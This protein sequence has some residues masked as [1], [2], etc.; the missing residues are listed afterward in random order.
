MRLYVDDDK[1]NIRIVQSVADASNM[2]SSVTGVIKQF[3]LRSFPKNIFKNVYIDTSET[4]IQKNINNL[5]NPLLDKR[6]Y[7]SLSITPELTIDDPIGGMS[8]NPIASSPISFL[9]RDLYRSYSKLLEDP[10]ERF[11]VHFSTDYITTNLNVKIA[12][13]SYDQNV[14]MGLHLKSLF[15]FG[16]FNYLEGQIIETEFPKT[17]VKII[18]G[19]KGLELTDQADMDI[20]REYLI[21]T[22][23]RKGMIV[24]KISLNTGKTCFFF[25]EQQN[26]LTL[27]SDLDVP[28]SINRN[29]KVEG[30]YIISFRVQVSCHMPN[31]YIMSINKNKFKRIYDD[32]QLRE[33][34][35][36][37]E[38]EQQD[39]G[40]FSMV[41]YSFNDMRKEAIY[42][43]RDDD[44]VIIGQNIFYEIFH[45]SGVNP[46]SS[47]N[48][49]PMLPKKFLKV[50]AFYNSYGN[51]VGG[52]KPVQLDLTELLQVNIYSDHSLYDQNDIEIDLETLTINFKKPIDSEFAVAIYV[53]RLAMELAEKEMRTN[54][55]FLKDNALMFVR[56]G[57]ELE[58]GTVEEKHV[59]IY[60]F[61]H[62]NELNSQDVTK[63]L[64]IMTQYGI[65][66]FGLVPEGH[67]NASLFK[68]YLGDDK[69]GNKIIK[70]LELYK[71]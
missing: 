31:A 40:S 25:G 5:Y 34:I 45:S 24:K 66:Y 29:D 9:K 71:V 11:C 16:F 27:F 47:L 43:D 52:E 44:K 23:K 63:S 6:P 10:D 51:Y 13:N 56:V 67:P 35:I 42:F 39:K 50:H 28:P 32:V 22:G 57:A 20:L 65:G 3:I 38:Q 19:L 70:C 33:E 1:N 7:P 69:Y 21:S 54:T 14:D 61:L 55:F 49:T 46:I 36:N 2:L 58:D 18:A 17:F 68:V 60:H 64:R 59:K 4:F 37:N 26:L 41:T 62:E 48:L 15:D 12:L 30:E 53:N 8:K